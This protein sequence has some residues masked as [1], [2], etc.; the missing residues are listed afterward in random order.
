MLLEEV[1]K[2]TKILCA[3]NSGSGFD[4]EQRYLIENFI[5]CRFDSFG[6]LLMPHRIVLPTADVGN[7]GPLGTEEVIP[8]KFDSRFA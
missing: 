3:V 7:Q 2:G 5:H 8:G 4:A 1:E 6:E